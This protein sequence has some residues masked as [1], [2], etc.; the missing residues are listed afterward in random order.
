[1]IFWN[2][3]HLKRLDWQGWVDYP[4]EPACQGD[5]DF[6]RQ[7]SFPCLEILYL[8]IMRKTEPTTAETQSLSDLLASINKEGQLKSTRI[9]LLPVQLRVVFPCLHCTSITLLS[10]PVH[11]DIG[12]YLHPAVKKLFLTVRED[13][14][15][16][17]W[18]L[19]SRPL[20][21]AETSTFL[22]IKVFSYLSYL[23]T[24]SWRHAG[25]DPLGLPREA[26]E[27]I[28]RLLPFA[29]RLKARRVLII[30][31]DGLGVSDGEGDN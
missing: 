10:T 2:I 18:P 25:R 9:F 3:P 11:P 12:E 23:P 14:V 20:N 28:G 6:M 21:R 22:W 13:D 27:F 30:D 1:L 31:E 5:V 29:L 7:C 26:A 16:Q 4:D 8:K 19:L 17:L 15:E 24:F